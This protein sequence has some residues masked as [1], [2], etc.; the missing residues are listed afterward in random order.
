MKEANLKRQ[1]TERFQLDGI[2]EK[3]KVW[4]QK[5]INRFQAAG[6]KGERKCQRTEEFEA[7]ESTLYDI[8]TD[9]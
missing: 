9:V 3:A 1:H 7:G 6:V 8:M 5:M 4:R 2:L